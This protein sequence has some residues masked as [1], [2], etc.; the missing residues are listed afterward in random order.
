MTTPATLWATIRSRFIQLNGG[1]ATTLNVS[2]RVMSL[3][4]ENATTGK[5][6]K[7]Y[8]AG[9]TIQMIITPKSAQ[10]LMYEIGVTGKYEVN[11]LT[12]TNVT[13]GDYI[14]NQNNQY[15]LV[16]TKQPVPWGNITSH[17]HCSLTY[18]PHPIGV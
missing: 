12:D 2:H 13:E 11:G 15:Y 14:M 7:Q 8:A 9:A 6:P 3:G 10:N 4:A 17:Y 18:Q 16:D 5:Y 1:D